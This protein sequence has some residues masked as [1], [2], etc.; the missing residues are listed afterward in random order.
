MAHERI[1][2][3]LLAG[4]RTLARF[5]DGHGFEACLVEA[6][7][8]VAVAVAGEIDLATAVLFRQAV[9]RAGDGGGH[10]TIDL[11][12]ATF[13]DSSGLA[14]LIAAYDRLGRRPDAVVL[15]GAGTP[16]R[17]V[18]EISGV[19]RIVTVI[20]DHGPDWYCDG[21]SDQSFPTDASAV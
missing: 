20:S 7:G 13:M 4:D 5:G 19:D 17:Q 16:I 8:A 3:G 11:T 10:V 18:L 14:V 15:R 2:H 21:P 9:D 12:H 6:D 1:A